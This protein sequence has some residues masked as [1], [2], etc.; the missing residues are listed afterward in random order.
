MRTAMASGPPE[1]PSWPGC[2]SEPAT[3]PRCPTPPA[4]IEC[5]TCRRSSRCWSRWTRRRWPPRSG[6]PTHGSV[7]VETG[8]NRFRELDLAILPGGV[9]EGKVVRETPTG[10]IPV[11]GARLLLRRRGSEEVAVPHQLQRWSVLSDGGEAGGVRPGGGYR[12]S[13][14]P[15]P[16]RHAAG[17]HDAGRSGWRDRGRAGGTPPLT[18]RTGRRRV[19]AGTRVPWPGRRRAPWST[20]AGFRAWNHRRR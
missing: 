9:I 11:A 17:A 13:G 14:A 18:I 19:A 1:K 5:G 20:T 15:R 4:A 10:P 7:S 6:F 12:R 2:A 16:D 8:P 3:S